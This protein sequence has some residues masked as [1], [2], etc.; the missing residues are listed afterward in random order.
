MKSGSN[1]ISSQDGFSMIEVM[2]SLVILLFGILGLVGMIVVSQRAETESYQRSQAL[3]L[4]QDMVGRI[5]SNRNV[6]PCYAIS[7]D[8]ANAATPFMGIGSAVTPACGLG[9]V[10]AYTR[11][12]SDLTT[13][14]SQLIG[15]SERLGTANAGAMTGAR[16]CISLDPVAN[17]YLVSVAWQGL[18]TTKSPPAAV[19]CGSGRYGDERLRRVISSTLSIANLN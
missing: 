3:L 15:A 8:P 16:G 2:V 5:R 19:T 11:S 6:A 14:Q 18:V 12:N 7:S 17:I 13:W 4:M 10:Q 1:R 9:T